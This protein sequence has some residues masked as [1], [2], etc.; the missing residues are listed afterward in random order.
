MPITTFRGEKSVGDLADKMFERLTPKQKE[1]VEAAILKAN[2]MMRDPSKVSAGTIVSVP[3]M[4]ELKPKTSRALENP[5]AL[6]ERHVA[7][8]LTAFGQRFETRTAE[9]VN[10]LKQELAVLK[11]GE[12]KK[13]LDGA[14]ALQ[15]MAGHLTKSLD[16]RGKTLRANL[17]PMDTVLQSM[18]KDLGQ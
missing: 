2:P 6:L 10:D 11:A 7:D 13:L 14:P 12:L 15:E 4:A 5:D 9:A 1:K 17:K 18:R 16:A 8:A 3:D